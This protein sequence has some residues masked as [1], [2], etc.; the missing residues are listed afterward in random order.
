LD[1][2]TLERRNCYSNKKETD[3]K[4]YDYYRYEFYE[5][6]TDAEVETYFG[7]VLALL[8]T[9]NGGTSRK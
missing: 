8:E 5:Y 1:R 4:Q 6:L 3:F 9:T 2:V 7:E